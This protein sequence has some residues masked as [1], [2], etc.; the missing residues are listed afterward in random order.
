MKGNSYLVAFSLSAA[1]IPGSGN[2]TVA[3]DNYSS[4]LSWE[5]VVGVYAHSLIIQESM[6]NMPR[7]KKICACRLWGNA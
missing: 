3:M 1:L 6:K 5:C 7:G 2:Y 4:D